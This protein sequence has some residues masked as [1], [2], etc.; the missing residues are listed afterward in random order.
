M[1]TSIVRDGSRAVV[2]VRGDL[3]VTSVASFFEGL[4]GLR[5]RNLRAVVLDLGEVGKID[6][7]GV[8]S[9][10]VAERALRRAGKQLELEHVAERHRAALALS[11]RP[12][13]PVAPEPAVGFF[14]RL[15]EQVVTSAES[16]RA[17]LALIGDIIRQS[18]AVVTRR[19]RLPRGSVTAQIAIMG[20]DAVVVVGMLGLLI[21]MTIA[22]QAEMQLRQFGAQSYAGDMVG[23]SVVRELA[24]MMTAIMLTGRTGAAIAAELGTMRVGGEIDAL[25]TMGISPVRFLVVPRLVALTIVQPAL[26]LVTAAIGIAGGVLVASLVFDLSPYAFWEHVVSSLALGDF[27]LA[28]GKSIVFAWVIGLA[29][30]QVGLRALRDA[31]AVGAATTRAVVVAIFAIVSVDAVFATLQTL[32]SRP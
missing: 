28:L 13:A 10:R 2:H 31:S 11:P 23:I 29:A 17:L 15:G 14:E 12:A 25:A 30:T 27:M 32:A 21:G 26:T 18:F 19:V 24:P 6:S 4:R 3:V 22:F 9:V 20:A 5:R 8:A 16:G 1:Q 7:A